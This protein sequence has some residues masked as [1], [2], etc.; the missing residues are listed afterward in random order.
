MKKILSYISE[1]KLSNSKN[2]SSLE[3]EDRAVFMG[4]VAELLLSKELFK[5][6]E[7]LK[8]FIKVVF[9][10]NPLEYLFRSR[11]LLLSR[12]IRI[13][14]SAEKDELKKYIENV[15]I[16]IE[17]T[18][19]KENKLKPAPNKTNKKGKNNTIDTIDRWRKVINRN[20]E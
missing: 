18:T 16:Y 11:T 15:Y 12:I 4:V 20:N 5:R 9:N 6:N 8:S 2:F 17:K 19:D 10:I 14:E 3:L 1:I 13:I 7:E